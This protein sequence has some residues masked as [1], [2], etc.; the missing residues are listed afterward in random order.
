[1]LASE[2][3]G[4]P[5]TDSAA[6]LIVL[7]ALRMADHPTDTVARFHMAHSPLAETVG[8][9][10]YRDR[11]AAARAAA[12]IRRQLVVDGYG[13]TVLDWARRLSGHCNR[14]E[15]NRLQQL[16]EMAYAYEKCGDVAADD[17]VALSK[18]RESPIPCPPTCA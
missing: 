1:V 9:T 18:A 11:E 15:L 8:M 14:R 12:R 3:G 17:F 6:V 7:S 13:P 4:N 10:D 2:E 16:V 5:L